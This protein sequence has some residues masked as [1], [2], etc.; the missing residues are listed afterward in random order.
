MPSLIL[1]TRCPNTCARCFARAK[2]QCYR[3]RGIFE[4]GW[5]NFT[6]TA[7]ATENAWVSK[8]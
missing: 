1:T 3:S 7:D 2:M 8:P 4:F 6:K 5:D